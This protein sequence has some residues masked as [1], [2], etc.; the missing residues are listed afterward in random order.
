MQ[1]ARFHNICGNIHNRR[2]NSHLYPVPNCTAFN[3]VELSLKSTTLIQLIYTSSATRPLSDAALLSM[4]RIARRNNERDDITGMLLYRSGCFI[5]VMEGPE[6]SV[7]A[8]H[9]R[10]SQDKRH[11]GIIHLLLEP[12]Q[13]R[14]FLDHSMGFRNLSSPGVRT[15]P[16]YCEFL[17]EDWIGRP[18]EETPNR[19][20]RMLQLFRRTMR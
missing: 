2:T 20:I 13:E 18:T 9:A 7:L 17:N 5:Q 3:A 6:K 14:T 15:T 8:T 12:I 16:G 10:I 19:A 4:L 11:T 1:Q